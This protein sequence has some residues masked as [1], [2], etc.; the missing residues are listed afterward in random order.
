MKDRIDKLKELE[1]SVSRKELGKTETLLKLCKRYK[2]FI[3][4]YERK[5]L[6]DF[7]IYYK[8]VGRLTERQQRSLYWIMSNGK[9]KCD[10]HQALKRCLTKMRKRGKIKSAKQR[11][12]RAD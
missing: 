7:R 6:R 10:A 9:R 1:E 8:Q 5:L 4:P 11:K 12:R 2:P 3:T